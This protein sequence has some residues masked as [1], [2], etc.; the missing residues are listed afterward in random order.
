MTGSGSSQGVLLDAS[1][2]NTIYYN[3]VGIGNDEIK[4]HVSE[5]LRR[6]INNEGDVEGFF[7][8]LDATLGEN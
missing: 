5:F 7:K 3:N 4:N 2:N 6:E 8:E 1:R